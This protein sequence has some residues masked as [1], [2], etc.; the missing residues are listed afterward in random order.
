MFTSKSIL[1]LA[2]GL[3]HSIEKE[4][5]CGVN[6]ERE[7]VILRLSSHVWVCNLRS[8]TARMP[9]EPFGRPFQLLL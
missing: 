2:Q 4:S 8:S 9:K 1:G 7:I 6:T 5:I 3:K